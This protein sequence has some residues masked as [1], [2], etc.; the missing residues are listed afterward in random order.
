MQSVDLVML[1]GQSNM[2]G[3]GEVCDRFPQ[4]APAL[5]PNAGYEFRAVSDPTR[6]YPIEEPFGVAENRPWGIHEARKTG[7]MATAFANA[8]Y[9]GTSVPVVGVSASKGGSVIEQWLPN[10]PFLTD[11]LARYHAANAWLEENG[12]RVRHRWV[13][14]CQGES[15][16][17][18]GTSREAYMRDFRAMLGA[19]LEAGVEKLLLVRIGR[20]NIP[21]D[22]GRYDAMIGW[23]DAI[24]RQEPHVV[25]VSECL[26]GL[27][28]QGMMKD[29]FHYYQVGYNLVGEEAGQRA[30]AY[31]R[32]LPEKD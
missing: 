3:R 12:V 5:V 29:A 25:S 31:V 14:W 13:L 20:C 21:Q 27:R 19:L 18:V 24:A 4:K 8:Y 10:R 22:L 1:M 6:L 30:A 26:A 2:A 16:A 7:S 23:Q 28:E 11:A 17:D 9:R 15:D 32:T